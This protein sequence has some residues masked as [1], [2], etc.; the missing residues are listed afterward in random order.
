MRAT[1]RQ[2][3]ETQ[4][5]YDAFMETCPTRQVM[6]T[7]GDKWSGLLINV[8][9]DGSRRHSERARRVR[10]RCVVTTTKSSPGGLPWPGRG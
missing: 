3:Y 6:S 8:L 5:V 10:G 1:E 4:A 9:V 2:R 7:V